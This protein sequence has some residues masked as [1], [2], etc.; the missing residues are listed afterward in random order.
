M[1]SSHRESLDLNPRKM[2]RLSLLEMAALLA[3]LE[4]NSRSSPVLVGSSSLLERATSRNFAL[5]VP[6][7]SST[8]MNPTRRSYGRSTLS[9][10]R[11]GST[12][13]MTVVA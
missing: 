4:S 13:S 8:A 10:G 9:L 1:A 6:R 7:M 3:N 12:G 5:S 11:K 2:R